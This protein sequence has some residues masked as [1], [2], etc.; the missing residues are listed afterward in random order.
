MS[1]TRYMMAAMMIGVMTA[2]ASAQEPVSFHKQV[3][4]I[5]KANCNGCHRPGKTK[6][7]LDLTMHNLVLKGGKQGAAVVAGQPDN[8]LLIEVISGPE[9]EM[10][11]DGDPLKPAEVDLI[12][13]WISEGAID[14]TPAVEPVKIEL[15]TYTAPP[16]I[17]SLGFSPDGTLLA[18]NGYHEVV[19]HKADGSEIIARLVTEAPRIESIAFSKDG[20]LLAACGGAPA[21]FGHVQVWNVADRKP[22]QAAKLGHDTLFGVSFSPDGETVAV[23]GAEKI[24]R[25]VSI[26][27]GSVLSEFK[28]HGDWVF[29]TGF[30]HDGK[31]LV[32]GGRDKALKLIDVASGR[33]VDDINNPLEAVVSFAL[34]PTEDKLAYGGDM[35]IT[36]IYN[37]SDNQKRTAGRNDTNLVKAMERLDHPV[38]AVAFSPDGKQIAVGTTGEV[39]VYEIESGK[40]LHVISDHRGPV[41]ALAWKPDGTALATG[42]FDGKVRLF[43]MPSAKLAGEFSPVPIQKVAADNA[44][45]R[46]AARSE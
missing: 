33:F 23:G 4:P 8:S 10:P 9:P 42:G 19:L 13:R 5:L 21:E 12:R 26:A 37:I 46:S 6:G 35:G 14:D 28:A 44:S 25:R 22:V 41:Y 40:R 2:A 11:E 18:V 30:T 3:V 20:K 45:L 38:T 29:A 16:V 34:H 7:K 39:R 17:S 1:K 15:P 24:V 32:S 36:R 31:Q 27:D 43:E